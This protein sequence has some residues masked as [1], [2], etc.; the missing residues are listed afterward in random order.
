MAF[1]PRR[2]RRG[3]LMAFC[4]WLRFLICLLDDEFAHSRSLARSPVRLCRRNRCYFKIEI[5]DFRYCSSESR[6][7][8]ALCG[9]AKRATQVLDCL[10]ESGRSAKCS[11]AH[12]VLA[13]PSCE[14]GFSV[15]QPTKAFHCVPSRRRTSNTNVSLPWLLFTF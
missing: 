5:L 7:D 2:H 15:T 1:P 8:I 12:G 4:I 10:V 14:W 3:I 11:R 9:V 6:S 13:M